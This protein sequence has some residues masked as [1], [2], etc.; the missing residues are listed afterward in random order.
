MTGS[1][2]AALLALLAFVAGGCVSS[3]RWQDRQMF[4][5]F[6]Q[7]SERIERIFERGSRGDGDDFAQQL[8]DLLEAPAATRDNLRAALAGTTAEFERLAAERPVPRPGE[9]KMVVQS[10]SA[11]LAA[12]GAAAGGAAGGPPALGGLAG[13]GILETFTA[14]PNGQSAMDL[15][16][17]ACQA[18]FC[19]GVATRSLN[20][21]DLPALPDRP[22]C[23]TLKALTGESHPP[24]AGYF[25][26]LRTSCL[27]L[28]LALRL[29]FRDQYYAHL[30]KDH[31]PASGEPGINVK[32]LVL[33]AKDGTT[34]YWAKT[35]LIGAFQD[36][37][38]TVLRKL[39]DQSITDIGDE[40]FLLHGTHTHSGLGAISPRWFPMVA[41][42]D[43]FEREVYERVAG[44]IV[45]A[46]LAARANVTPAKLGTG[47][48]TIDHI[49]E[50]RRERC[51]GDP[52]NPA[53]DPIVGIVR[54]DREDDSPMAVVFNFAI[55]GTSL[56]DG[57]LVLHPDNMGYAE[58]YVEQHFGGTAL[59][60]NGTEGDVR[61]VGHAA[62]VGCAL[63]CTVVDALQ[64]IQ[65]SSDI[66]LS[67][68]FCRLNDPHDPLLDPSCIDQL[69]QIQFR[70]LMFIE[71]PAREGC[72]LDDGTSN[73]V[74]RIPKSLDPPLMDRQGA[75][76][77]AYRID[78]T[79]GAQTTTSL[80]L[81]LPVEPITAIGH[82]LRGS[83]LPGPD[84]VWIFGLS[85]AHMGYAVTQQEYQQGGY[86]SGANF[87]GPT[88]GAVFTNIAV[89]L[90]SKVFP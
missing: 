38:S 32:A 43:L 47:T 46:I 75:V 67:Y 84:H 31:V 19:A 44:A 77:A 55:H 88:E 70:P 22:T 80:V 89:D 27:G 71:D 61:P 42:V 66:A 35:D 20:P 48:A 78:R 14:D 28:G 86:E 79:I 45:E 21:L 41:T 25:G 50:N 24:L 83:L 63:G 1:R 2:G 56:G 4:E 87:F 69:E 54:I 16:T 6:R 23:S 81:T 74:V 85:N 9:K 40:N 52:P 49:T 51:Q 34:F 64:P 39:H 33:R 73:V 60:F 53:P 82:D 3:R 65:T 90:A 68:E 7:D 13:L 10:G 26:R 76:L 29:G 8:L 72:F 30:F 18:K 15:A 37:R 17:P 57:N 58:R 12:A 59:F 62:D 36:L 11:A 5:V